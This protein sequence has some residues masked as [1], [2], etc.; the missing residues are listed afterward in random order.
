MLQSGSQLDLSIQASSTTTRGYAEILS[1]VSSKL[2]IDGIYV[3]NSQV[4]ASGA[5][6]QIF[7]ALTLSNVPY[8]VN[9]RV[10][11]TSDY[12]SPNDVLQIVEHEFYEASGEDNYP[13]SACVTQIIDPSGNATATDCSGQVGPGGKPA[14]KGFSDLIK[15]FFDNLKSLGW[16]LVVGIIAI[17]IIVLVLAAY[18]PNVPSI[19]RA[20]R[21]I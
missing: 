10:R 20:A 1:D 9:M 6:D 18:G 11:T 2:P 21:P 17:V 7:G 15:E 14:E 4:Q 13:S 8:V 12:S 3:V 19:A 16:T 5:L